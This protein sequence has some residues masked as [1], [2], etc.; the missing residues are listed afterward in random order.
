[1]YSVQISTEVAVT[2]VSITGLAA[3]H[4]TRSVSRGVWRRC[5]DH[6]S[7]HRRQMCC[8]PSLNW[9]KWKYV[10]FIMVL[11][12]VLFHCK[13]YIKPLL[14]LMRFF[15]NKPLCLVWNVKVCK[16]KLLFNDTIKMCDLVSRQCALQLQYDIVNEP[17]LPLAPSRAFPTSLPVAEC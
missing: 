17:A 9:H 3:P 14:T 12:F 6:W 16:I 7:R 10:W 15:G 4:N 13:P 8:Q 11:L 2:T 1:M 5:K